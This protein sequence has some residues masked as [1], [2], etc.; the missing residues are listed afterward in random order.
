MTMDTRTTEAP[1]LGALNDPQGRWIE[2]VRVSVTDRCNYR[3]TYCMP[4]GGIE[5]V[6]RAD[7]LSFE[8]IVTIV[9]CFAQLGV[10]RLRITGGEPT[11]RRDL[12]ALVRRLRAVPGIEDLALST[13]GHRLV[14]LAAALRGAGVDRLNIS[15]DTLD[16]EKFTRIT[17]RGDVNCVRQGIE[18][19]RAAGFAMI[20]INTVAIKGFNDGEV[21]ALCA[22]AW[23]R[24]L[25]PRFIEQM[26][27]AGG[28]MF[29]PGELLSAQEIRDL[30]RAAH[31]DA[32]LVAEDGGPARGAGPARYWRVE[33]PGGKGPVR[34][35][36]IISAMTEHF[37][38]ACNRV[39][40]SASGALHACLGYDDA[41]SLREVLRIDGEAGVTAAIRRAI[42]GKRPRHNFG[43]LGIGGP[44]K[45]MI[46]IGG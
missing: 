17:R 13:N 20:K 8:E 22:Y 36:G 6:D 5:H 14:E 1:R 9:G 3:C 10:R 18:A 42:S 38:D 40:L 26:P 28:E 33:A 15:L 35:F 25:I 11:V 23:S 34:R 12:V 44:R 19:A 4:D 46:A 29:I 16:P 45:S 2:Y 21:A 43:L 37:C 31:P 24:D 7:I 32:T 39:R 27:M 41:V 30:V